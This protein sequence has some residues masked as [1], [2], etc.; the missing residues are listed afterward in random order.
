MIKKISLFFLALTLLI[1]FGYFGV[2]FYKKNQITSDV[3]NFVSIFNQKNEI[4]K[5][6]NIDNIEISPMILTNQL[7]IKT[8][9]IKIS[10]SL[11][12]GD[13]N[14]I[15]KPKNIKLNNIR[16]KK[17]LND[18][19]VL[20]PKGLNELSY[21]TILSKEKKIFFKIDANFYFKFKNLNFS[22]NEKISLDHIMDYIEYF[23]YKDSQVEIFKED[24]KS[25]FKSELFDKI[26]ISNNDQFS[27]YELSVKK[28]QFIPFDL[29]FNLK[30]SKKENEQIDLE[31]IKLNILD[32]EIFLKGKF[33]F[34]SNDHLNDEE[35]LPNGEIELSIV[36]YDKFLGLLSFMINEEDAMKISKFINEFGIKKDKDT[37]FFKYFKS[38]EKKSALINDKIFD[39]KFFLSN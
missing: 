8:L 9:D 29:L 16:I 17:T 33:N 28:N 20:V 34:A 1:I 22:N 39:E 2:F 7:E 3:K 4:L 11:N 37:H 21:K 31:K 36:K 30:K 19:F 26:K 14:E 5:I 18:T 38:D 32:S 25:F 10:D 23:E 24:K 6:E 27:S 12:L 15:I 13:F 35:F